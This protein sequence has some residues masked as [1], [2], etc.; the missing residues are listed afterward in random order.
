[1]AQQE[2]Q[3]AG[4]EKKA[5]PEIDPALFL[6]LP[7]QAWY[8]DNYLLVQ[9]WICIFKFVVGILF[10]IAGTAKYMGWLHFRV[11]EDMSQEG[12]PALERA[13]ERLSV[14]ALWM[15]GAMIIMSV[16]PPRKAIDAQMVDRIYKPKTA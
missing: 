3:P 2:V 16:I 14:M 6:I 8:N 15:V 12:D 1:M 13:Y 10:I 4:A 5:A 9:A 11:L 7:G